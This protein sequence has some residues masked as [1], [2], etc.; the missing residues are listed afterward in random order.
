M[1]TPRQSCTLYS[2]ILYREKIKNSF[3][4]LLRVRAEMEDYFW[5]TF[6][7]SVPMST[8]LVAI[9]VADLSKITAVHD[10]KWDFGIYS[11]QSAVNQTR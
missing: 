5:D 3:N 10:G 1:P 9:V 8:Y 7:R 11:R 6:D 4:V 2:E